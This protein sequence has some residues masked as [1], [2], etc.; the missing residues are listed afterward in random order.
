MDI[1]PA[2][3]DQLDVF[4]KAAEARFSEMGLGPEQSKA[5]MGA[6]LKA[7]AENLGVDLNLGQSK[8]ASAETPEEVFYKAAMARFKELG[9][10]EEE[11]CQALANLQG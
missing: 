8:K 10:T 7:E 1:Q 5:A 9:L 6:F 2:T 3:P 11:G 4:F